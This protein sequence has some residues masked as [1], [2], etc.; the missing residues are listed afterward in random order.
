MA[1][2]AL[3]FISTGISALAGLFGAKPAPTVTKTN[4]NYNNT[5]TS[6]PNIGGNQQD[7]INQFT[8]GI[9]KQMN[10]TDMTG[11]TG[12]GLQQINQTAGVADKMSQNILAAR[13]LS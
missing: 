13:G 1:A 6:T 5:S 11:Y 9:T 2:L 3:P 10:G 4:S 8:Q 12:Q 7:L